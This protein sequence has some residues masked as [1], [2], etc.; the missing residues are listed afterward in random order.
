MVKV[1]HDPTEGHFETGPN[2]KDRK[3][4]PAAER[5]SFGSLIRGSRPQGTPDLTK[6][7]EREYGTWLKKDFGFEHTLFEDKAQNK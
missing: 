6:A 4:A 3:P 1:Q 5:R 2:A 7:V